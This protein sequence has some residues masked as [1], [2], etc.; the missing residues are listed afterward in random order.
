MKKMNYF[1]KNKEKSLYKTTFKTVDIIY[2][3]KS[4][5]VTSISY[6]KYSKNNFKI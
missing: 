3:S 4:Q 6:V 1:A 2:Q 5:Y